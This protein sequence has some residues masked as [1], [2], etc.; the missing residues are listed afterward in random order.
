MM[1][2]DQ[3]EIERKAHL[4]YDSYLVNAR[5]SQEAFYTAVEDLQ[6]FFPSVCWDELR[7]DA[8]RILEGSGRSY[9]T[10]LDRLCFFVELR[11]DG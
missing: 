2:P 9:K 11:R 5:N 3:A 6:G 7:S 1:N 4:L 8:E 10:A